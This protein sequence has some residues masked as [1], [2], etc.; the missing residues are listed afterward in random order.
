MEL[1]ILNNCLFGSLKAWHI[2]F[3]DDK[4]LKEILKKANAIQVSSYTDVVKK[5][6]ILLQPFPE[7]Q[8]VVNQNKATTFNQLSF[9]ASTAA[10]PTD[11]LSH[12]YNALITTEAT[13][14]YN[15]VL[16]NPLI[17]DKKLDVPFQVGT[18]V[19]KPLS[20]LIKQTND[21][22]T[23]KDF[24]PSNP[25]N[26]TIV[27]FVFEALIQNLIPLYFSIQLHFKPYL[28]E[29][30]ESYEDFEIYILDNVSFNLKLIE[31]NK[32]AELVAQP[33]SENLNFGFKAD[34]DKLT[35]VVKTLN[36]RFNFLNENKTTVEDF[37]NVFTAKNLKQLNKEVHLSCATTEFEYMMNHFQTV[38]P[39][40]KPSIINKCK[41]FYSFDGTLIDDNLLYVTKNKSKISKENKDLITAIFQN[42]R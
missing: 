11:L 33:K 24:K 20:V 17:K 21:Y 1:T 12:Y 36:S 22:L 4:Q 9:T 13:R 35:N 2:N 5:L 34:I 8:K 32:E 30:Y 39:K 19:L 23:D 38:A 6:N 40:F 28:T 10:K 18:K 26:P 27:S 25:N 15:S 16:A 29:V 7:L 42:I 14:Y 37:I 41:L 31:I 3:E